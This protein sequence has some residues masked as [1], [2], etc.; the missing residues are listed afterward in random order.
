METT[1]RVGGCQFGSDALN[2]MR[3]EKRYHGWGSDFGTEYTLFDA[4]LNKFASLKKDFTGRR[5]FEEQAQKTPEWEW[6]MLEIEGT[7]PEP[8]PSD[9]IRKGDEPIGYV[10]SSSYGYRTEIGIALGYVRSG[11]LR[12]NEGC[13]VLAFGKTRS[14]VRRSEA[15]Y[16]PKNVRLRA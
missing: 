14:A 13:S 1:R 5:A 6:V 9:P 10:T 15:F 2:A 11:T 8:M 16:D 3:I 4:G 7:G 12:P